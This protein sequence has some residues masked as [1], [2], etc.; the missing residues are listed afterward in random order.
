M[1]KR[2]HPQ[3]ND[4]GLI[5]LQTWMIDSTAVRATRA[6]SGA[7]KRRLD[8]P[9]DHALSRS[10]GGLTISDRLGSK[11]AVA[12]LAGSDMRHHQGVA[13]SH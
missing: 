9:A 3:F 1:P 7:V 2:L 8:E 10:R 4:Q 13:E 6:S 12:A 5:D 11:A